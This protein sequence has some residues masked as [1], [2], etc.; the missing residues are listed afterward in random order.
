MPFIETGRS[1]A[2]DEAD[3]QSLLCGSAPVEPLEAISPFE[4][5]A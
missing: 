4:L 5:I 1:P 2:P 3:A